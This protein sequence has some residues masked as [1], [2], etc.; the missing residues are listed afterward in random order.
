MLI[1]SS[2]RKIPRLTESRLRNRFQICPDR[3][4]DVYQKTVSVIKFLFLTAYCSRNAP[5]GDESSR[6]SLER[7]Y[8]KRK[9]NKRKKKRTLN[10]RIEASNETKYKRLEKIKKT[11]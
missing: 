5:D 11:E 3:S 8:R 2:D 4:F 10:A 7:R 6:D 9:E 1:P